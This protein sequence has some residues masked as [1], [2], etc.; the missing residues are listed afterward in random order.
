MQLEAQIHTRFFYD[1]VKNVWRKKEITRVEV[2]SSVPYENTRLL[3]E[4]GKSVK[5][6][7]RYQCTCINNHFQF[8]GFKSDEDEYSPLFFLDNHISSLTLI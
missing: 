4:E 2:D 8:K 7:F 3:V 6:L 5:Y 1:K